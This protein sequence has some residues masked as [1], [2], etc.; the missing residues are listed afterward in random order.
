MFLCGK[1]ETAEKSVRK[2]RDEF[3]WEAVDMG[4]AEAARAIELLC[5]L[6]CVP[7]FLRD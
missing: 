1:S 2:I 5:M 6:W 3:G 7:G 4:S